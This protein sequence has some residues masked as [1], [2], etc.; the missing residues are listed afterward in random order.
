MNAVNNLTAVKE[1]EPGN[2]DSRSPKHRPQYTQQAGTEEL[3]Y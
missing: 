3:Y 2:P 1:G